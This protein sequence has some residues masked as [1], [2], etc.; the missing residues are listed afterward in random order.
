MTNSAPTIRSRSVWS[1]YPTYF[2][3]VVLSGSAMDMTSATDITTMVTLFWNS[4]S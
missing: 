3:I 2:S 4:L 1:L